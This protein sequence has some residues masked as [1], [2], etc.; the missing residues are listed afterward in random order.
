MGSMKREVKNKLAPPLAGKAFFSLTASPLRMLEP[1]AF[2]CDPRSFLHLHIAPADLKSA[3]TF[4][5]FLRGSSQS[6]L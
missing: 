1:S 6:L 2:N 3:F 5:Y 4:G